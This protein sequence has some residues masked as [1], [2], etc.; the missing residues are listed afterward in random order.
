[1]TQAL[2]AQRGGKISLT[3]RDGASFFPHL[4]W[5]PPP[6]WRR[7]AAARS[8]PSVGHLSFQQNAR[9]DFGPGGT[10]ARLE[11]QAGSRRVCGGPPNHAV[12]RRDAASVASPVQSEMCFIREGT[13]E[14]V[15]NGT[16]PGMG[17]GSLGASI[18]TRHTQ[19]RTWALR[20]PPTLLSAW[21]DRRSW[22]RTILRAVPLRS[23]V[24]R[25]RMAFRPNLL[26][27]E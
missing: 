12:A 27:A 14:L 6:G 9:A 23:P 21:T 11:G 4:P 10:P 17:R 18:P 15:V 20:R 8:N 7:P 22:T 1:M 5:S 19:S 26:I 13:V 2:E 25:G 3:R 16:S 24:T